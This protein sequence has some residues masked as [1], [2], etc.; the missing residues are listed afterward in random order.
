MKG[1]C[2]LL[3]LSFAVCFEVYF[4]IR[5]LFRLSETEVVVF[6]VYLYISPSCHFQQVC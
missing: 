3:L 6:T 4:N 1:W 2:G 5:V